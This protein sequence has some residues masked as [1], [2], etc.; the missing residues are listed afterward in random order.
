MLRLFEKH[1]LESVGYGLILDHESHTGRAI[2]ADA[3]SEYRPGVGPVRLGSTAAENKRSIS[4]MALQAL[5]S[6]QLEESVL[7]ELR[8]L[9]R[10]IIG[11]HLG[12]KPLV[13]SA[14][15]H[16]PAAKTEQ[17]HGQ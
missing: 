2:L 13:S 4:G 8:S 7:P 1:L 16:G 10:R 6:E 15:F 5:D 3:R 12:D 17:N 9:M 11:Y 14:L